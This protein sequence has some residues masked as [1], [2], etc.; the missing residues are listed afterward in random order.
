[1]GTKLKYISTA[2]IALIVGFMA[3]LGVDVVDE[4]PIVYDEGYLPY[5]C[6]LES[7][8]DY[9][10]YKLSRVGETTGVN[11][12]CYYNRDR[13]RKYKVCSTGWERIINLD[14]CP[15]AECKPVVIS[16][17]TNCETG[18]TD[19]FFCDTIGEDARCVEDGAL[20]MPW[21]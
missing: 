6:D 15:E 8:D 5:G 16:Y 11:R 4:Q 1:M 9:M 18:E 20:T 7:V 13:T 19:K 10:C 3:T 17:I 21:G 12:N 14:D 2:G